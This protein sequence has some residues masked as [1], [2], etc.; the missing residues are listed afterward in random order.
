M[1]RGT[2]SRRLIAGL[3][4]LAIGLGGAIAAAVPA[5]A[6]ERVPT[7]EYGVLDTC[8]GSNVVLKGGEEIT[9][10]VTAGGETYFPA[11]GDEQPGTGEQQI[12]FVPAEAGEIA[13]GLG[14]P[15][16][17]W[18]KTHTW[19]EPAGLPCEEIPGPTHT[20]PTCE[21]PGEIT[22]PALPE[23]PEVM[24]RTAPLEL[25]RVDALESNDSP[26]S[27]RF[28]L[29]GEEVE[30][31]SSHTVE[32]GTYVVTLDVAFTV[33]DRTIEVNIHRWVIEIEEPDCEDDG[34]GGELPETGVPTS[35]VAGG[36]ALLLALGGG[37]FL[38]AR[39]RRITF[40]A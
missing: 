18:P 28:R 5:Q 21:D 39:R 30:P 40:T 25:S 24:T 36:A 38:L 27:F 22:I 35:L 34:G 37:L 6:Q 12:V 13:I 20:Q 2:R 3:A 32:P 11:A 29:D 26:F 17:G 8:V 23:L 7:P 16:D 33:S 19:E 4:G 15:L 10:T 9:W 14:E 1:N 31:G